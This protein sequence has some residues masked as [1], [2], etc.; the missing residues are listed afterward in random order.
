VTEVFAAGTVLWRPAG[1]S[2]VEL[3]LIHRPRYDDWTL[4]KGKLKSG[5]TLW[6][7]AFRETAEETGFTPVLGRYLGRISYPVT[8]PVPATKIVDYVAARAGAGEFRP[9][10][11]VDS[12]RW[13][14]PEA[15]AAQL[16][17]GF[18]V[19][20]L[21]TFLALPRD[22]ATL[23]LVRH[24]T[25]GSRSRWQ[26]PDDLRP[27]SDTGWQQVKA[28][29]RLLPLFGVGRVHS[30]PLLRCVQTVQPLADDLG[31]P[32]IEEPLLS[33]H[34]YPHHEPE[35]LARVLDLAAAGGTP[36]VCSQGGVIPDLLTRL[37]ADKPESRKGS[38]WLLT[39]TPSP[40]LATADYIPHP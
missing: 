29:H 17:H 28:L 31:V 2:G 26:G 39:F 25:A 8:Q 14:P 34:G 4:P 21:G 12:L 7:G 1:E 40:H 23:L 32:I 36:V 3:A 22:L 6:A 30:A 13:L 38:A 35:A 5:E 19:D 20:I 15:A 33:E 10:R 24:A 37:G 27:L 11:E 16:T 18:D 9:N